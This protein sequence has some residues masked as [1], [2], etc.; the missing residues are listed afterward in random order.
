MNDTP[1][2]GLDLVADFL[3]SSTLRCGAVN[4]QNTKLSDRPL[5]QA[6]GAVVRSGKSVGT[7]M[8]AVVAS[9]EGRRMV[10][11]AEI[12]QMGQKKGLSLAAQAAI[13]GQ[14]QKGQGR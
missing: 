10:P 6:M 7:K 8:G 4:G 12:K 3:G 11:A 1:L 5:G 2:S 14:S 9:E 13:A